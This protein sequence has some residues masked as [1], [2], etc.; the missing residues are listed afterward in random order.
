LAL[1]LGAEAFTYGS[2]IYFA[3][4]R[5]QPGSTNGERLLA[6]EL[7]H[8]VQQAG[9]NPSVQRDVKGKTPVKPYERQVT[10]Q[11]TGT[12]IHT[13]VEERLIKDSGNANL[14][15]EAPIPGNTSSALL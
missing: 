1:S 12:D 4:G 11:E 8:V 5:Y 14:V 2:D 7:T 9:G 10:G 3:P 15:T 6:H 13:E